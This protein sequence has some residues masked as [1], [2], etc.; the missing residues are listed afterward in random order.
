MSQ[1]DHTNATVTDL[2]G[3][4]AFERFD[5]LIGRC[6]VGSPLRASGSALVAAKAEYQA[7]FPII[8]PIGQQMLTRALETLNAIERRLKVPT[9]HRVS[10]AGTR[11]HIAP[12]QAG[13]FQLNEDFSLFIRP[14]QPVVDGAA[15]LDLEIRLFTRKVRAFVPTVL[16]S[17]GV[18]RHVD[19]FDGTSFVTADSYEEL[20]EKIVERV[21]AQLDALPAVP[22]RVPA[23]DTASREAMY[24]WFGKMAAQGLDFHPDDVSDDIVNILSGQ[25]V[26]TD[27]EAIEVRSI[28][29]D[30]FANHGGLVYDAALAA[31][32]G[33]AEPD[34][35][36]ACSPRP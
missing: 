4:Q 28:V 21:Q 15:A 22:S 3:Q 2:E 34:E 18:C 24:E 36:E 19:L 8:Q 7:F 30:L 11:R 9:S 16:L 13:Q 12:F 32:G 27:A 6:Q 20:A 25:I 23:C 17:E 1:A 29:K 31:V 14:L 10:D 5:R 33:G 26:F 35:E